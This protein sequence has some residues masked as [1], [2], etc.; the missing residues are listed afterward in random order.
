LIKQIQLSTVY[1]TL[2]SVPFLGNF[3]TA[4]GREIMQW[5]KEMRKL[6]QKN[7]A[8]KKMPAVISKVLLPLC[9]ISYICHQINK[10]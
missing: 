1:G 5:L 2:R 9:E 3:F 7:V 8:V 10:N 4:A 6:F